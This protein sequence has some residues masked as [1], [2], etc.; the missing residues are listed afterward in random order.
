MEATIT[1]EAIL[2]CLTR[3]EKGLPWEKS[4][5]QGA[6]HY[7]RRKDRE[8]LADEVNNRARLNVAYDSNVMCKSIR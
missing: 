8:T 3:S 7:L 5:N 2:S 6:D 4:G 1:E